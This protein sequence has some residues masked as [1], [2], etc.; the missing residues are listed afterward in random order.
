MARL[1][2]TWLKKAPS[3]PPLNVGHQ[4]RRL[5]HF[6]TTKGR[7]VPKNGQNGA[8]CFGKVIAI[9]NSAIS[10]L[11]RT[12]AESVCQAGCISTIDRVDEYED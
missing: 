5:G 3:G 10:L 6:A 1:G 8:K 2:S 12:D 11:R 4:G 9:R 7:L